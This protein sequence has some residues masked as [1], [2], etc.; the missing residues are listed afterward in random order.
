MTL[1]LKKQNY[2]ALIQKAR[3]VWFLLNGENLTVFPPKSE[4]AQRYQFPVLFKSRAYNSQM[5]NPAQQRDRNKMKV[6]GIDIKIPLLA[7]YM[8]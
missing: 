5:L 3:Y 4:I 1:V 6:T 2:Y 7:E 8:V